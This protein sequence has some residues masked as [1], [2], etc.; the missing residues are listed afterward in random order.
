MVAVAEAIATNIHATFR[1]SCLKDNSES[2]VALSCWDGTPN[3]NSQ[4]TVIRT[5]LPEALYEDLPVQ[6]I[7]FEV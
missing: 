6:S 7:K 4:I 2:T 1:N 5:R 3:T